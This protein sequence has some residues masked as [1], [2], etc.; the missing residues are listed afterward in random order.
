MGQ[1]CS[2]CTRMNKDIRWVVILAAHNIF[3]LGQNSFIAEHL[4][5]LVSLA[6]CMHA[7]HQPI[8]NALYG[9]IYISYNHNDDKTAIYESTRFKSR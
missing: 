3:V 9:Y 4:K 8:I 1:D 6:L 5:N 7:N 2:V